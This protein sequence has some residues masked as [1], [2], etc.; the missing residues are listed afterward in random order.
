MNHMTK[1]VKDLMDA[2]CLFKAIRGEDLVFKTPP[3]INADMQP[4][5]HGEL[6]GK[7]IYPLCAQLGIQTVQHHLEEALREAA[8]DALGV[9]CAVQCYYVQIV[10]ERAGESPFGIDRDELPLFLWKKFKA[11]EAAFMSIRLNS[12]DPPDAPLR[13]TKAA[14]ASLQRNDHIKFE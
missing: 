9:F 1:S 5:D 14:M 6:L 10:S 11:H 12:Y 2:H 13:L 8:S 3:E 7:A 4:T